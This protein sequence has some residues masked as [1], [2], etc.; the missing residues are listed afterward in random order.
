MAG[1]GVAIAVEPGGNAWIVNDSQNIY[2]YNGPS[3]V[4]VSGKAR[5]IAVGANGR[6]WILGN[7]AVSGGYSSYRRKA[8]NSGWGDPIPG[9]GVRISVDPSGNAW[10]VNDEQKI[11]KHNGSSFELRS[12]S[13]RD[14][15]IGGDGS[16]WIIGNGSSSGGY[17]IHECVSNEWF[18]TTGSGVRISAGDG[19][20]WITN[21][22]Q[23]HL[24]QSLGVGAHASLTPAIIAGDLTR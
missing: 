21:K 11:Y 5:D 24:L 4:Q 9:G 22:R 13:A 16:I 10:F 17:T 23:S 6:V 20:P 14:I 7:T 2:Q 15:S 12:G 18:R 1:A 19:T 8:D 3:F